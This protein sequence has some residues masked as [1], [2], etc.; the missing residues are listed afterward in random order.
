MHLGDD[1]PGLICATSDGVMRKWKCHFFGFL[2]STLAAMP[3]GFAQ[4]GIDFKCTPQVATPQ[5][6]RALKTLRA[7]F[8]CQ[9]SANFSSCE[10]LGGLAAGRHLTA[11]QKR[12]A[13]ALIQQAEP[14]KSSETEFPND[15]DDSGSL[16]MDIAALATGGVAVKSLRVANNHFPFIRSTACATPKDQYINSSSRKNCRADIRTFDKRTL[17]F[18][19]GDESTW[20]AGLAIP[21]VCAHYQQR[22]NALIKKSD[23]ESLTCSAGSAKSVLSD[24]S[25]RTI[26]FRNDG[27][28]S[29]IQI[30]NNQIETVLEF[31]ANNELQTVKSGRRPPAE[32]MV[33]SERRQDLRPAIP[34][35]KITP[36][37]TH[38][39]N[40]ARLRLEASELAACCRSRNT[41]CQS[42]FSKAPPAA[43]TASQARR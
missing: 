4:S 35:S 28:F 29:K 36:R 10:A 20:E 38:F 30:M 24:G 19:N 34:V 32:S 9:G 43:Q 37:H 2:I 39:G 6:F 16:M 1:I 21:E 14:V 42:D 27:T 12:R 5:S 40:I 31:G 33:P 7:L 26:L 15:E 22:L 41:H 18:L 3:M 17:D 23:F 8:H 11:Q 13:E 25:E